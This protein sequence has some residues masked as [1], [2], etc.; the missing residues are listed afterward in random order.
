MISKFETEYLQTLRELIDFGEYRHTRNADTLGMFA[1]TYK[2]YLPTETPILTTKK[3]NFK[4]V[5][6]E[7]LWMLRGEEHIMSLQAAGCPIWNE[8]ADENGYIGPVYGY[9]WRRWPEITSCYEQ[10]DGS[11][12]VKF[13]YIDQLQKA[14]DLIISDPTSRRILVS[15][16]NVSDLKYMK[17]PP[18]HYSFQFYVNDKPGLALGNLQQLNLIANMRSCDICVGLPF[19]ILTYTLMLKVIAALTDKI[20]GMLVMNIADL[21]MYCDH[22]TGAQ[23]QLLNP[24]K[25]SPRLT[26]FKRDSIN[27]YEPKDFILDNYESC[28]Y[29]PFKLIP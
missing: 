14:I 17:L 4:Y 15:A 19:D 2:V 28:E 1:K 21:H 22:I 10:S 9:Q 27:N 6:A 11:K 24:M 23:R 5:L 18:C 8:F 29:I 3:V 7:F 20:P 13:S 26:V 16:W 25:D 12:V